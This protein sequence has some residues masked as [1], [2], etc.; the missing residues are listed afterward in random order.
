MIAKKLGF[1][2]LIIVLAGVGTLMFYIANVDLNAHKSEI[3]AAV[4][5]V[6]GRQLEIVGDLNSEIA[7][8]PTVGFSGIRF[9]NAPWSEKASMI[10]AQGG[11]IRLALVS[12]LRGKIHIRRLT[13]DKVEVSLEV[14]SQGNGNWELPGYDD[15]PAEDIALPWLEIDTLRINQLDLAYQ[16]QEEQAVRIRLEK[17]RLARRD[18]EQSSISAIVA[19]LNEQFAISGSTSPLSVLTAN[20]PFEV[21]LS[22]DHSMLRANVKGS[23][24]KPL[25]LSGIE[26]HSDVSIENLGRTLMLFDLQSTM[27]TPLEASFDIRGSVEEIK[28]ANIN[29][30]A[31]ESMLMGA[32][33]F[34]A[35]DNTDTKTLEFALNANP[36]NLDNFYDTGESVADLSSK[37]AFST[38]ALPL[39]ILSGTVVN[40]KF[41]IS[42]LTVQNISV[43]KVN[44]VLSS[45]GSLLT[46][47]DTIAFVAGG[48]VSVAGQV[49][50]DHKQSPRTTFN[51]SAQQ[52]AL[53]ELRLDD[54]KA[55]ADG[56]TLDLDFDLVGN[57]HSIAELMGTS[58]GAIKLKIANARLPEKATQLATTDLLMTLLNGLNPLS[59]SNSTDI[60]CA[61]IKFPI[62]DG[63]AD[64][65]TGIGIRTQQ[66]NILGGG[67]IDLRTEKIAIR[68]KPKP[69][70]GIGLNIA[71]LA[72]FVGIGGTIME[73]TPATDTKGIAT[74]GVKIGA[75][76]ATAG[77]SILAEGLFDRASSDVDVCAVASGDKTLQETK[78]NKS[79]NVLDSAGKKVKG[80]FNRLFGN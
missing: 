68:A 16:H 31:Q 14:D 69:R 27:I 73:P 28:L 1:I 40:G 39:E 47:K 71:S 34:R 55:L 74:A 80:V 77:L 32:L 20:K 66:L 15:D 49:D 23:V 54:G 46:L 3:T 29:L 50:I 12:L 67:T 75:A 56:G 21:S 19:M 43:E 48:E 51:L 2:F 17:V 11:E 22:V 45:N 26:L 35:P 30:K 10:E 33:E 24:A 70:Q 41:S 44:G 4:K 61:V 59:E 18:S 9:A 76:V 62:K 36:F 7:L 8:T 63:I 5:N 37:R 78:A 64:N 13:L 42:D 57:G 72:D 60:E 58:N 79:S 6:T 25:E 52:L 53:D 38:T 65:E